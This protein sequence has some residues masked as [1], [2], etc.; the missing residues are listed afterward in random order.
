LAH[1]LIS[2]PTSLPFL[3]TES[4]PRI[5]SMDMKQLFALACMAKL[6]TA[7]WS[8]IAGYAP[9]SKVTDHNALDLDQKALE[10]VLS[11]SPIN[12]TRVE[13]I[14]SQGGNSKSY[15]HFTGL[16]SALTA[17]KGDKV[18][19]GTSSV[20]GKMYSAASG[21]TDIKVAYTTS[22]VQSTYV[23]CKEGA[24]LAAPTGTPAADRP[25][26]YASA[27]FVQETLT[28]TTQGGDVVVTASAP[29]NKA[30][31]TLK[32]FSTKAGDLMFTKGPNGGCKGASDRA[33]DGC[34]YKDFTMYKNYYGVMDYADKMVSAAIAAGLTGFT[35]KGN[36]DFTGASD[37]T[38]KEVI[39]KGTTYMNAYMYAI[40]EFEDAI[41]DC[42]AGCANG[43][44]S[45]GAGCN[46]LST[47]AVH[48]WDEGVAFYTG[49]L[50]GAD[51]GG[52]S[53]GVFPYRLAEKRCKNY[54]TCGSKHNSIT[55]TSYV[56][57][58]F[59][60]KLAIGQSKLLMGQ[61]DAVRPV[62]EDM[63][64]LM[65]IPLIQGTLRYAYKVDRMSGADKEKAEGAI[66]AA[67]IVPRVHNCN[68]ADGD[69]IM[70]NMKIGASSTSFTAVKTAF[71][72]NYACMKI[73]CEEVGGLW[74]QAENKYYDDAGPCSSTSASA[75]VTNTVTTEKEKLPGW[76][77]AIIVIV[78]V[79]LACFGVGCCLVVLQERKSRQPMFANFKG[80]SD[81]V[82]R[83]ADA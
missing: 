9:G 45:I 74:F 41:D 77:I 34:P 36:M 17:G 11:E 43:I 81:A 70:N 69:A 15:A 50:E 38:R 75:P 64:A 28:V 62:L 82:G 44:V 8:T 48:A 76:A 71:E 16:S 20:E 67:A 66:F 46:S 32:G 39:K 7:S 47:A 54:K 19:G 31:R 5:S 55:G 68:T 27:C 29:T 23:S 72:K 59:F 13:N 40:R 30:G 25:F 35:G 73:T 12:Y 63:V 3:S 80:D 58:E 49:S 6:A 52:N 65:S 18:V 61:C 37:Q 14:Y 10:L 51:V 26:K 79:L 21:V 56:N 22:E 57:I 53:A 60:N 1:C 24:L 83:P 33:T 78:C 42:K 4:S 2:Y